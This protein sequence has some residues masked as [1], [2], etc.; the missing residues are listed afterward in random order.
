[1]GILKKALIAGAG[2][3]ASYYA[4]KWVQQML[5]EKP[6]DER[7]A[8]MQ[9]AAEVY[10]TAATDS[11]DDLKGMGKEKLQGLVTYL[12]GVIESLDT[13]KK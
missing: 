11:V 3:A 7:L 13:E 10:K 9:K 12:N 2:A 5:E 6:L 8:D 4:T 1:M